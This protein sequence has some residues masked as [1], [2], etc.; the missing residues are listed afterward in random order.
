[1]LRF[2]SVFKI[3]D[4]KLLIIDCFILLV[5]CLAALDL[6]VS[7]ASDIIRIPF[8]FPTN[9]LLRKIEAGHYCP[10]Y[11]VSFNYFMMC[12]L[13]NPL[14]MALGPPPDLQKLAA[15]A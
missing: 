13:V 14:V 9:G 5:S 1:M 4:I 12:I 7:A 3:N 11:R 6:H 8:S 10:P 15:P 2:F